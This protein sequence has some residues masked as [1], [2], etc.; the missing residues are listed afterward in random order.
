MDGL[1]R[2][3]KVRTGINLDADLSSVPSPSNYSIPSL[4]V[5]PPS[6]VARNTYIFS[7]CSTCSLPFV[8][9]P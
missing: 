6:T 4:S 3:M 2:Q 5:L 9:E 8:C 7:A 1:G